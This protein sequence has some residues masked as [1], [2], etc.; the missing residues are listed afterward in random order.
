MSGFEM[1]YGLVMLLI[2]GL[3]AVLAILWIFVPFAVFGIKPLLNDLIREVR[4]NNQL[5]AEILAEQ[6]AAAKA[7][8]IQ[9]ERP[10]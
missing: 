7:R 6:R 2:F 1:G 8:I 3:G 10:L 9:E 4:T 5:S